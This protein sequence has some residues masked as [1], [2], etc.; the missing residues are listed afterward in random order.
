MK[1]L[2]MQ[3]VNSVVIAIISINQP[4]SHPHSLL[5]LYRQVHRFLSSSFSSSI[6]SARPIHS[7]TK[8]EI[9]GALLRVHS[10]IVENRM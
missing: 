2:L 9:A 1:R 3:Q 6:A 8:T 5:F 7:S 4:W 10:L